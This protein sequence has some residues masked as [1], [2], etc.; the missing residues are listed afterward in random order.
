MFRR[1]RTP[2]AMSPVI[3][4][5]FAIIWLVFTFQLLLGSQ[6]AG[7]SALGFK[8][9]TTNG[10]V[11][12]LGIPASDISLGW[13]ATSTV[14]GT[15]QQTY[16]VRIGTGAGLQDVWDSGQVQSSRQVGVTLPSTVSLQPATRYYWQVKIWD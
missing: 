13:S 8:R 10:R 5:V 11:N 7:A 12:P 16:Q 15:K 4:R 3:H 14:R 1:N 2:F 9:L 6:A